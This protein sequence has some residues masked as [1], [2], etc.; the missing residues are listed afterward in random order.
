[1]EN[2][3]IP[4]DTVDLMTQFGYQIIAAVLIFFIGRW[5]AKLLVNFAKKLMAKAAVRD[6]LQRFLANLLYA[7]LMAAIVIATINQ[8][9]VQTT[10]LLAVVGAAGLAIGLWNLIR[11]RLSTRV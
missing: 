7:V 8:L 4:S 10:S 2:F 1:M 6:T 5:I 9:G 11:W 3:E